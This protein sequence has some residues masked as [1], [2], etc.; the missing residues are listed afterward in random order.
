MKEVGQFEKDTTY[1]LL[2]EVILHWIV[3]WWSVHN[4]LPTKPAVFWVYAEGTHHN[5]GWG[6]GVLNRKRIKVTIEIEDH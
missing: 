6:G 4:A 1:R 2:V 5:L 3:S